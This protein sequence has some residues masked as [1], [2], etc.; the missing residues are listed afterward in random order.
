MLGQE[1]VCPRRL[2]GISAIGDQPI[3]TFPNHQHTTVSIT[4]GY[5]LSQ[6]TRIWLNI[7]SKLSL[8]GVVSCWQNLLQMQNVGLILIE[9]EWRLKVL[10]VEELFSATFTTNEAN[11]QP[12]NDNLWRKRGL[13]VLDKSSQRGIERNTLVVFGIYSRSVCASPD[14][15]L[16]SE[17][18]AEV[19]F[20]ISVFTKTR[21]LWHEFN[22]YGGIA[23]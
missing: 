15:Q 9:V 18:I 12:T 22:Y 19:H 7:L 13:E 8:D 10:W 4:V 14:D 21:D 6:S 1:Q 5:I 2:L 11:N 16:I 20:R 23:F 17:P 3:P